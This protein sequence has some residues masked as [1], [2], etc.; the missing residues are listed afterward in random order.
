MSID[1]LGVN[2]PITLVFVTAILPGNDCAASTV[3]NQNRKTLGIG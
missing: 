2:V 3:A 1:L